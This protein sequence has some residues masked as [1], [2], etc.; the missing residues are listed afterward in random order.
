MEQENWAIKSVLC[1]IT[2]YHIIVWHHL[3]AELLPLWRGE[4]EG[5][6]QL[7]HD[8]CKPS[9]NSADD[10]EVRERLHRANWVT[11]PKWLALVLKL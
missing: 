4:T 6:Q 1:G 10:T 3:D 2:G 5:A 9:D 7:K 11:L 8:K